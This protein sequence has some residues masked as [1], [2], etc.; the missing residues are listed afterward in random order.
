[1]ITKSDIEEILYDRCRT[2]GVPIILS[3]NMPDDE[4]QE[5][6]IV[7]I[8]R[9][10]QSGVYW[11]RSACEVN[12]V[13]PDISGEEDGIRLKAI[14]KILV[15]YMRYFRGE[16]ENTNYRCKRSSWG[17]ESS[18]GMR[19]HYVNIRLEFEILNIISNE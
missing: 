18:D 2:F 12:W 17:R 9:P 6:R 16:R 7:I 8:V 4:I 3:P 19:C 10:I 11:N 13:V 1:M 14:E 15:P 5:E